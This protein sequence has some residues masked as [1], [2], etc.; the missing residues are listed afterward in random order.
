MPLLES[1]LANLATQT[2]GVA[3]MLT[4]S[5]ES[6]A[7]LAAALAVGERAAWLL[8]AALA[9]FLLGLGLYLVVLRRF[10]FR[11]L[12]TGCG[13]HWVTSGAWPSPRSRRL[14]SPS[15]LAAC[16]P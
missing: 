7:V 1:V 10:D 4:V 11:Q 13:G 12:L 3:F 9:S 16:T 2:V 6:L 5:T 15:R 14:E 8:Y